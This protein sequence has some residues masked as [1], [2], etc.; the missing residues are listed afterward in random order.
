MDGNF[1]YCALVIIVNVKIL[2]SSYEYT[3]QAVTLIFLSI[4][5]FFIVYY[6]LANLGTYQ[7]GGEFYHMFTNVTSYLT[8]IFFSF[9]YILIDTGMERANA[10]IIKYMMQMKDIEKI[11]AAEDN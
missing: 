4:A 2:V 8:L 1:T 11:Q 9:T 6:L 3:W 7:V 5:S 10:E